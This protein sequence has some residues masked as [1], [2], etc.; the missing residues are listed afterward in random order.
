FYQSVLWNHAGLGF[1][2]GIKPQKAGS[3]A[4]SAI[5]KLGTDSRGDYQ[6]DVGFE[7]KPPGKIGQHRFYFGMDPMKAQIRALNVLLCW[8]VVEKRWQTMKPRPDRPLWDKLTLEIAKSVA[9]GQQDFRLDLVPSSPV[10][11]QSTPRIRK[12]T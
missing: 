7:T 6:R 12:P 9:A 10:S 11:G 3:M 1:D 2:P 5:V 8:E 4:R